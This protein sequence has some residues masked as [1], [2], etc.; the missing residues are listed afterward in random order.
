MH[1]FM[2]DRRAADHLSTN[3]HLILKGYTMEFLWNQESHGLYP[4]ESDIFKF[5][6]N[7]TRLIY[8]Y[9]GASCIYLP[10]INSFCHYC[11]ET[12]VQSTGDRTMSHENQSSE[13]WPRATISFLLIFVFLYAFI[14][15][16]VYLLYSC[17]HFYSYLR[18]I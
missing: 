9:V 1:V 6:N 4:A 17:L 3:E 8:S 7:K 2:W 5:N 10:N 16:R 13:W 14:Y 11:S 18:T 15:V 12:Y